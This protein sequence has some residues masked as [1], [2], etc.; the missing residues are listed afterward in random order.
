MI[1][2]AMAKVVMTGRSMKALERFICASTR[3]RAAFCIPPPTATA[4]TSSS[5]ARSA[6]AAN[7]RAAAADR[8]FAF[9]EHP[10]LAVGDDLLATVKIAFDRV[11]GAVVEQNFHGA[12]LGHQLGRHHIDKLAVGT[13][14]H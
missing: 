13:V 6:A 11:I 7:R 8:D 14:V 3:G 1:M 4:A 2:A 10:Q 9:G 5:T 12:R